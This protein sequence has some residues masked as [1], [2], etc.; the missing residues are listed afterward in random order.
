MTLINYKEYPECMFA[1]IAAFLPSNEGDDLRRVAGDVVF[2]HETQGC[3]YKN[4][5]LHSYNDKPAL[6]IENTQKWCKDGVLHREGDLPAFIKSGYKNQ[7][8]FYHSLSANIKK[9]I[10]QANYEALSIEEK[11]KIYKPF[12]LPPLISLSQ[13][14]SK[15]L[16]RATSS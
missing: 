11:E 1:V 5:V 7:K 16:L 3:T 8:N 15:L 2:K 14:Q 13:R 12:A 10:S 4:G 9:K 6:D